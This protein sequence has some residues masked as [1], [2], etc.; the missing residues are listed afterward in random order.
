MTNRGWGARRFIAREEYLRPF[1]RL[2]MVTP[3]LQ[4]ARANKT[5][6]QGSVRP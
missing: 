5:P 4:D 3:E 6:Q 2:A 1:A